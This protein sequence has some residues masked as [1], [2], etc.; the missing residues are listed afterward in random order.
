MKTWVKFAVL[1]VVIIAAAISVVWADRTINRLTAERDKYRN[2]TETLLSD[3]ETYRVRD[4]L[5][6]ARVQSLE[7]TV[8]EY[9]RF[10]A[11]DAALI[12]QLKKRNRDLAAVNKTQSQ[13]IIDLR[14]IPRDTV[15]LVRDSIIT[16]AV[17]VHCG[18][19]WFDFDG[20]LTADQFTGKLTNRDSL[21][22]AETVKYKRFLGFL[23]K[24]RRVQDR[25]LDVVSRNPH[26]E[27]MNVEHIVIET[28]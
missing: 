13:T 11:D 9:E 3:V 2:N 27:I 17:A 25:Q 7:L 18:D 4:S 24:T 19:A 5:N 16:P 12:K 1:A 10:R 23:W 15:V 6:A 28:K 26:T 8:K 21:L 20:I 22:L 14:A